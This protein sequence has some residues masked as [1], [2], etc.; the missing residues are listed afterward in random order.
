MM[1]STIG[2]SSKD[3]M[4]F[5]FNILHLHMPSSN[6]APIPSSDAMADEPSIRAVNWAAIIER[7]LYL[8]KIMRQVDVE[9]RRADR[10]WQL[11]H[12]LT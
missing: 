4:I 3:T 10:R 11:P 8:Q 2:A 6:I 9:G 1:R 7:I 5:H 12:P